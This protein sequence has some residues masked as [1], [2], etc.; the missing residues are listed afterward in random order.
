M[1]AVIHELVQHDQDTEGNFQFKSRQYHHHKVDH[2]DSDHRNNHS[3]NGKSR[4]DPERDGFNSFHKTF[5]RGTLQVY[6]F[7]NS[8][9]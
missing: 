6:V 8:I 1:A 9:I 3:H 5:K 7:H 4:D 2:Y